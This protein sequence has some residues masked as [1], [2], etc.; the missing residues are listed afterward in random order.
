MRMFWDLIPRSPVEFHKSFGGTYCLHLQSRRYAN[1][2]KNKK[3]AAFML[4]DGDNKFYQDVWEVPG[5]ILSYSRNGRLHCHQR[6]N[7]NPNNTIKF[8]HILPSPHKK[9]CIENA[10]VTH[11]CV[12]KEVYIQPW[13]V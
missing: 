13:L 12:T 11:M 10:Y 9:D 1:Q 6:K 2:P 7:R 8:Y 3:Q 4:E 5:Y